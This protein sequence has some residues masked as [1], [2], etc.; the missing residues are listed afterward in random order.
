[1]PR[2]LPG[3]SAGYGVSNESRCV[4]DRE[5]HLARAL[6]VEGNTM[7]RS[8]TAAH[9]RDAGVGQVQTAGRVKEARLLLE[10]EHFDIVL[11]T[12]QF[13]QCPDTGQDLLDELRREHLLPHSTVFLMVVE[14]A[15]YHQV[16]EA[17]ESALDG[18]LV[19][20]FTAALLCQR[21]LEARH[22][23]SQLGDVL[24]ALDAGRTEVAFARALKRFND[25]LPYGSYCGRLAAEL[26]L[27][28]QRPDDARKV[29]EKLIQTT[30]AAWAR[31]GVARSQMA[32]GDHQGAR[33][34]IQT[35]L[36][37]DAD[38]ADA[39]DL[40]GRILVEQCDFEGAL[41]EYRA[42]V[43]LTPGCLLRGQHAGAL[44][45]YQ[46]ANAEALER[47]EHTLGLGVRS[48]LFDA[49]SL[50]LIAL[51]RFD[52]GDQAG[53]LAMRR[54]LSLYRQRFPESVRL[55]RLELAARLLVDLQQGAQEAAV[56]DLGQLSLQVGSDDFDLESA[57]VLISLWS[58]V[59]D[60]LVPV[61]QHEALV[62]R[63]A[64]RFCTSKAIG[65][66][67]VGSARR[68]VRDEAVIRRCQSQISRLAEQAMDRA[69]RGD[70][71]G[72]AHDL[73]AHGETTLNAKLLEMAGL[74]A[75]RHRDTVTDADTLSARAAA[76]VQRT[77]RAGNLIA[78]IQRSGRSPGG[79]QVRGRAPMEAANATA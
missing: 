57:N 21:L 18:L 7:M 6:L 60:A 42:A 4:I 19:R 9:L 12:H 39:H 44:A 62:E 1:M 16:V 30:G 10:R 28:M 58:R 25:N 23:K 79:L 35:V 13:D 73:L 70:A 29:F 36:A 3:S 27:T 40:M 65:E 52:A 15:T 24:Q 64:M 2:A 14:K 53:V 17:A 22:R 43:S 32:T 48:K 33:H 69:L 34:S 71:G 75:R 11:C 5:I 78:G 46:G 8:V 72:A 31:L 59:P 47:L 51:L 41:R 68:A 66:V 77:C 20:P 67:L 26:L 49:L 55:Q 61:A 76:V 37:E 38:S 63:I 54:Q 50:V 74:I 45:F 56:A